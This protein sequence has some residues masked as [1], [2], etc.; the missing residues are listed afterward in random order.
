MLGKQLFLYKNLN[1]KQKG[2]SFQN[3]LIIISRFELKNTKK[4]NKSSGFINF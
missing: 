2:I 3:I 1:H 4:H